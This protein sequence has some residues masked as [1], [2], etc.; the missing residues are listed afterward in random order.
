MTRMEA[1]FEI[2]YNDALDGKSP[3][4]SLCDDP[5]YRDGYLLGLEHR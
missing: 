2:G 5:S 4:A 3:N 1:Y